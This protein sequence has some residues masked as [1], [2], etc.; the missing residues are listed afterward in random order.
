[1]KKKNKSKL[2]TQLSKFFYY[3]NTITNQAEKH[4]ELMW[5]KVPFHCGTEDQS[6]TKTP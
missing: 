1:M 5:E 3:F 2:L 4:R 6:V